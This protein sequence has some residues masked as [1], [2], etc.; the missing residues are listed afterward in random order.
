MCGITGF[1]NL[2]GF[3]GVD[4]IDD[5]NKML[6]SLRH[7][8]PNDEGVWLDQSCGIAFAHTRLAVIDLSSAGRQPM[9][10]QSGRYQIVFNGEIYNHQDVR[11]E[12]ENTGSY[13]W[14][15]NSDTET[16]LQAI[17]VWGL[18]KSLNK[19]VGMFALAVWDAKENKLVLARDR[20]GEKPL[21][22]GWQNELLLFGSE[23]KSI[24]QHTS[25]DK[26]IDRD[27]VA[28]YLKLGYIPSPFSIWKDIYKLAP[29]CIISF[30]PKNRNRNRS[31]Q[32]RS[33]W[34]LEE[35][36]FSQNASL[37]SGSDE[38]AVDDLDQVLNQSVR[39]QSIADVSLGAFLSG[40][41]DSSLITAILQSQSS[42]PVKT[43]TI[44]FE[45]KEFT[46]ADK[47]KQVAKYLKTEHSE[48]YVTA[49]SARDVI[50]SLHEMYDEPFGDPS[51]IPTYLVSKLT[52]S[53]VTVALSGDGGDELFGGYQRYLNRR[54]IYFA[55]LFGMLPNHF[56]EL[57]ID[58]L[59]RIGSYRGIIPPRQRA[60]LE[61]LKELS[62][63]KNLSEYYLRLVSH[64]SPP[65]L[66][67]E[68][69]DYVSNPLKQKFCG[70]HSEIRT[71]MAIDSGSYLPDCI[72]A[73]VDRASMA[74]SLETRVPFLD[75]RV[76]EFAWTVPMHMKVRNGQGKWLL[77]RLLDRYVPRDLIE[78]PKQGFSVPTGDWIKGPLR[79]WTEDLLD[80]KSIQEQGLLNA[81]M[82][83]ERWNEHQSGRKDWSY[84]IWVLLMLQAWIRNN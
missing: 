78:R 46:E 41:I 40:G 83:Q 37:F 60:Q 57:F 21:Y 43:F 82:V 16:L 33:F 67:Y 48:Y 10:S 62:T 80:M 32:P 84:S 63:A 1:Y 11:L 73:K 15:G 7:R 49:E 20:M 6:A 42:S 74:V 23:L 66:V 24:K 25:F 64:W 71:M 45:E 12:L 61:M 56:S 19:C 70:L 65:P 76:V 53:K 27:V 77:R 44:G 29:G 30:D 58:R 51:A 2:K 5:L 9:Q 14:R 13:A 79:E 54:S 75:H 26:E 3:N 81:K 72:L 28:L 47:A 69:K 18:E 52:K 8:G 39:Q 50:P 59:I 4:P 17:D 22:Y 34:S 68:Y 38:Q 36:V 31:A 55:R 35:N